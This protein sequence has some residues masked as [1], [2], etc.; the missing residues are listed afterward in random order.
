M[1]KIVS[2]DYL[3]R[4]EKK[5]QKDSIKERVGAAKRHVAKVQQELAVA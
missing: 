3:T 2:N 1:L 5:Q 4:G